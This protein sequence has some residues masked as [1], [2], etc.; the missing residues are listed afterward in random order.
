[1]LSEPQ[2]YR[3]TQAFKYFAGVDI[4]KRTLA[5]NCLDSALRSIHRED[6]SA[7]TLKGC[8]AL[9][10][11]ILETCGL[12]TQNQRSQ[13]LICCE[14]T[15]T[16]STFLVATCRRLGIA[17]WKADSKTINDFAGKVVREKTDPADALRIATFC[18]RFADKYEPVQVDEHSVEAR[19]EARRIEVLQGTRQ[20]MI[21]A[22]TAMLN[23]LGAI[24][25]FGFGVDLVE[26]DVLACQA[27]KAMEQVVVSLNTQIKKLD[28][29]LEK[30]FQA[31]AVAAKI[32]I[33]CSCPGVGPILGAKLAITT[34]G[35]TR[36][37][38]PRQLAT[39]LCVAPHDYSSGTSVKR[40]SK[41]SKKG[42]QSAKT[43]LSMGA[44][45]SI[46]ENGAYKE[47][48]DRKIA[49]GK[50]HLVVLNAIRNKILHTV[51]A[52]LRN[53]TMYDKNYQLTA[54]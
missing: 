17:C 3:K 9:L 4:S 51:M 38:N 7:N 11:R 41:T 21:K 37:L 26:D 36:M 10:R 1:M 13:L 28:A 43:I 49:Q 48:Y 40:R 22:R 34:H 25:S 30:A 5:S 16:M 29:L 8:D 24:E 45:S 35:F 6:M 14:H 20:Q 54:N 50:L 53:N 32:K 44:L 42:D 27:T 52:C 23:R 18:Y 33:A 47:Y 31:P 39:H 46:R 2:S 19:A 12:T 15:G